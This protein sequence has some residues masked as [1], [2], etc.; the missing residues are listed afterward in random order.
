M[1][2]NRMTQITNQLREMVGEDN[3]AN[4]TTLLTEIIEDNQSML[5]EHEKL[6]NSNA[7]LV[8]RNG[9]LRKANSDLFMKVGGK[10]A[11]DDISNNDKQEVDEKLTFD[12]LFNEKG[13]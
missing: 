13:E 9:E 11:N 1:E 10:P 5:N 4:A 7:D 8:A 2:V 12:G 6:S 3:V